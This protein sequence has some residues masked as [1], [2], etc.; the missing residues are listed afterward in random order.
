MIG[1]DTRVN[2]NPAISCVL[3]ITNRYFR[4]CQ[5]LHHL[6]LIRA[7]VSI[8]YI[9]FFIGSRLDAS[10]GDKRHCLLRT[11]KEILP[12]AYFASEVSHAAAE[13]RV[14]MDVAT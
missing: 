11:A 7:Q 9:A 14:E 2:L 8:Q 3:R 6:G 10:I 4:F 12:R 1:F 5:I 13:H